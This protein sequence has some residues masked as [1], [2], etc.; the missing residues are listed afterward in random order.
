MNERMNG[1]KEKGD[2]ES[3]TGEKETREKFPCVE[4]Q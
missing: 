4:K 3:L 1:W 2:A